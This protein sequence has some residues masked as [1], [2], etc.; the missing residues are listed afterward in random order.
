MFKNYHVRVTN[1]EHLGC[2]TSLQ[3]RRVT[4]DEIAKLLNINIG[5]V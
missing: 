3:N 5:S 2:Q 1:A 4:V